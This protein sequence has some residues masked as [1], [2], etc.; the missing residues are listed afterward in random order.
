VE[1][2]DVYAHFEHLRNF[3]PVN[4]NLFLVC[5]VSHHKQTE[6]LIEL[7][8]MK[9]AGSSTSTTIIRLASAWISVGAEVM[10]DVSVIGYFKTEIS[11]VQTSNDRL[12]CLIRTSDLDLCVDFIFCG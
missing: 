1:E 5:E 3:Y 6:L 10:G 11:D 4:R 2:D 12:I 8:N 7:F 9:Q